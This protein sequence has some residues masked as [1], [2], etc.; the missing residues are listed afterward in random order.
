MINVMM[1]LL[2]SFFVRLMQCVDMQPIAAVSSANGRIQTYKILRRRLVNQGGFCRKLLFYIEY[3]LCVSAIFFLSFIAKWFV[4]CFV[5]QF[6]IA[7]DA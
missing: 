2:I 4:E 1:F 7:C 6:P 3:H 5:S